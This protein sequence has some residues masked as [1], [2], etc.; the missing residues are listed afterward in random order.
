M[1][2]QFLFEIPAKFAAEVNAGSLIRVG[3]LL[4]NPSTGK[5]VAHLQETGAGQ[6]LLSKVA[7]GSPLGIAANMIEAGAAVKTSIDVGQIK[8]MVA[9]LQ[10]LQYATLGVSMVGLGVTVAGFAYM[11]KRFDALDVRFSELSNILQSGFNEQRQATMRARLSQVKGLAKAAG[12]AHTLSQPGLEYCRIAESMSEQAAHFEGEL[13]FLI[14]A[15]GKMNLE[16]FWQLAQ[17][18]TLSNSVRIDCRMRSNEMKNAREIAESVA[19]DYQR[20]FDPLSVASFKDGDAVLLTK[21]LRE[22]TDAAM[23]KPYLIEHLRTQHANGAAYLSRIESE[24][25][26]PLLMLKVA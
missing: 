23:T 26:E 16:V 5:I 12:Q 25:E 8:K 7:A 4:K 19:E 2:S 24:T 10:T 9:S 22:I 6:A 11:H 1:I 13:E 20:L 21:T 3:A 15:E 17:L 14:K 18:L